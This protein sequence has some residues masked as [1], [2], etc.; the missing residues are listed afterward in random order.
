VSVGRALP[1]PVTRRANTDRRC[2]RCR[3]HAS[4]C[5]CGLIPEPRLATRTRL[6]LFIHRRED[7]KSTNTGRLAAE[8]LAN[9]EVLVRGHAARPSDAFTWDRSTTVP[10]ILF[11]HERAIPLAQFA[12]RALT[13][14]VP[15]GTWRQA[16]KVRSRVLGLA[17]VP[18]VSL[19]PDV[20]S[21]YRL[22]AESHDD[23]LATM[24]AIARAMGI[25]EGLHVRHALERVFR[26]TV[27]RTLW[28]RG[29]IA[30][31]DVVDGIPDRAS[32]HDP[33][34]GQVSAQSPRALPSQATPEHASER[35]RLPRGARP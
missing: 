19:P 9:S 6:V 27:E 17:D 5:V 24:E 1:Y 16:S 3:L 10:V 15:D 20:P 18:Y 35:S 4:L 25:L 7:R 29:T 30:T 23:G 11:P 13:L 21:A 2:V 14:I 26:A 22:R 28:S 34:S 32:R 8:C 12:D 33:S 31:S